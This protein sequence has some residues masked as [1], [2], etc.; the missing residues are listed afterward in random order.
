MFSLN[1]FAISVPKIFISEFNNNFSYLIELFRDFYGNEVLKQVAKN[2]VVKMVTSSLIRFRKLHF[3]A[4]SFVNDNN[5]YNEILSDNR[6]RIYGY[7]NQIELSAIAKQSKYY[8]GQSPDVI[9][10]ILDEKSG[11]KS[12]SNIL[13]HYPGNEK[14]NQKSGK[15][16]IINKDRLI[17][18]IKIDSISNSS[19]NNVDII[20][21]FKSND[22]KR[23]RMHSISPIYSSFEPQAQDN[24]KFENLANRAKVEEIHMKLHL[25][26]LKDKKMQDQTIKFVIESKQKGIVYCITNEFLL[27]FVM[28]KNN[29]QIAQE[30]KISKM[31]SI[32]LKDSIVVIKPAD[33]KLES[34]EIKFDKIENAQTL[35]SFMNAQKTVIGVFGRPIIP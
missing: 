28:E 9:K 23:V 26:M 34:I 12:V 4:L 7:F 20:S 5:F 17:L 16:N 21:V 8:F 13:I 15:N 14:S 35:Q 31:E 6:K 2:V 27:V 30:Y 11:P 3:Y 24:M 19:T 22:I 32:T 25:A 18:G 1:R 10:E 33:T 29:F